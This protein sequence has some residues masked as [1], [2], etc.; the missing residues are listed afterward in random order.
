[1]VELAKNSGKICKTRIL[2]TRLTRKEENQMAF[3]AG[4]AGFGLGAGIA[5]VVVIILLLIAMGIVF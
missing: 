2:C 3:G 4:G 5:I 1:M